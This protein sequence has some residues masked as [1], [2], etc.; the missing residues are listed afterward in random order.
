MSRFL[1]K[2]LSNARILKR[3]F[4][5][6][7]TEPLH[8]NLL[9]AAVAL[10]GGFRARVAFDLVVRQ[11]H[12]FGLLKAADQAREFG[13]RRIAAVEFGVAQGAGIMNLC[14]IARRVSRAT[15]VEIDI[16]GFD[17]GT[18]MPPPRDHRDHPEVYAA[19]D[20]PMPNREELVGRL[21]PNARI[22][23]GDVGKTVPQFL[24]ECKGVVGFVSFD[25]DYYWST[26]EALKLFEGDAA[27]YL[28]KVICYFDDVM[29]DWH[30]EFCGELAAIAD[31][32]RGHPLRKI[33]RYNYLE[34]ERIFIRA[35]WLGGMFILHVL[36]HS[37]RQP[38]GV[39]NAVRVLDNPYLA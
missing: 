26:L 21:P 27:T 25:V 11:N 18:G 16:I 4:M 35:K 6:R 19:G 14:E 10:F 20:F 33:S 8:L 34:K 31:F 24:A 28:P 12:A 17:T 36:D 30:N 37:L 22:Y 7:L 29:F 39:Q 38:G 23:F 3:V 5:E 2:R 1:L 9:S 32:N 15:G 13:I